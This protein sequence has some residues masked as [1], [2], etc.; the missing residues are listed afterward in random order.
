M[1]TTY[2]IEHLREGSIN[3]ADRVKHAVNG[4]YQQAVDAAHAIWRDLKN[5]KQVY[6]H[7]TEHCLH[8]WHVIHP[9]GQA[10]DRNTNSGVIFTRKEAA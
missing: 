1:N 9:D 7:S 6:V 10:E 8:Y 5:N 2:Y 4:T 3:L